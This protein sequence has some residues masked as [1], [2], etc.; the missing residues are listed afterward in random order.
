[1][2]TRAVIA[3][4]LRQALRSVAVTAALLEA[5]RSGTVTRVE[6][7][8]FLDEAL[9]AAV[10][11]TFLDFSERI[12]AVPSLSQLTRAERAVLFGEMA[13]GSLPLVED[14]AQRYR[15]TWSDARLERELKRAVLMNRKDA[16]AAETYDQELRDGDTAKSR[17]RRLRDRRFSDTRK[18]TAAKR[19]LMVDRYRDRLISHR[20]AAIARDQA[21]AAEA[22]VEFAHWTDR[23]ESGDP[24]A[25]DMRKFW[26][27]RG[28]GK[29]RD[30]HVYIAQDYPDGLPLDVPFVTK[31]GEMRYAHDS[32]GHLKDRAGCRCKTK[33]GKAKS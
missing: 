18:M 7:I 12:G 4:E 15:S 17:R 29:V 8:R 20:T 30:S 31:W 26:V 2:K 32:Q 3:A 9:G 14:A 28:D 6:L 19:K 5:V 23:L 22:A 27:N 13:D 33:I 24:E 16:K 21:W 25:Q 10:D 1:M 11:L